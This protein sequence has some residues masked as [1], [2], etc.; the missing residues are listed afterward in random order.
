MINQ[1]TTGKTGS[2][3]DAEK[4]SELLTMAFFQSSIKPTLERIPVLAIREELIAHTQS[5]YESIE[6]METKYDSKNGKSIMSGQKLLRAYR[7]SRHGY[8][9]SENERRALIAHDGKIP[10]NLPDLS[11]ALWHYLLLNFPLRTDISEK[12]PDS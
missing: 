2:K 3:E 6:A 1:I 4:F 7:N 12:N 10:D 11:I 9:I 8:K 5:I